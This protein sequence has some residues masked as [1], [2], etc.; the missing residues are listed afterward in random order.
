MMKMMTV[1]MMMMIS[2]IRLGRCRRKSIRRLPGPGFPMLLSHALRQVHI[3]DIVVTDVYSSV[4]SA[5]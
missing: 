3:M 2:D 1:M 5:I 4:C